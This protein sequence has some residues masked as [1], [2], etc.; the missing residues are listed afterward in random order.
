MQKVVST[1]AIP[2][3][4]VL[5]FKHYER[6]GN[7]SKWL[8]SSRLHQHITHQIREIKTF[9]NHCYKRSQVGNFSK[10]VN[11]RKTWTLLGIGTF[12]N[13]FETWKERRIKICK[14]DSKRDLQVKDREEYKTQDLKLPSNS[15]T[16][17]FSNN[18]SK[19][20]DSKSS[21]S[22]RFLKKWRFQ[23]Q[24]GDTGTDG[25]KKKKL[26]GLL[27]AAKPGDDGIQVWQVESSMMKWGKSIP[28]LREDFNYIRPEES[29]HMIGGAKTEIASATDYNHKSPTGRILI[30]QG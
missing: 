14:T 12:H 9:L 1:I 17:A 13:F 28:S 25:L 19:L 21:S 18:S 4:Q 29:N 15:Q 23:E 27:W 22:L 8:R 2:I 10:T 7:T 6:K 30:E 5:C 20:T 3:H 11:H 24:E 26:I 16:S